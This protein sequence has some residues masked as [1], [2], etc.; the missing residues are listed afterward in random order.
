M[1]QRPLR[2]DAE[3]KVFPSVDV[4][5]VPPLLRG[6][7]LTGHSAPQA[8]KDTFEENQHPSWKGCELAMLGTSLFSQ[9]SFVLAGSSRKDHVEMHFAELLC[10]V[11]PVQDRLW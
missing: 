6:V 3:P 5:L 4:N 2:G 8:L 7:M 1:A 9:C 11:F 10:S